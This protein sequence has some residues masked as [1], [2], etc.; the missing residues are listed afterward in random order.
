MELALWLT[1][2]MACAGVGANAVAGASEGHDQDPSEVEPL[3]DSAADHV[4]RGP[5][6]VD[7]V[8]NEKVRVDREIRS[9]LADAKACR[10]F[11]DSER[12]HVVEMGH[13]WQRVLCGADV[14]C[15]EPE[16]GFFYTIEQVDAVHDFERAVRSD[17]AKLA[18]D[19]CSVSKLPDAPEGLGDAS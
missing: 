8:R 9:L 18:E 10:A 3:D 19:G 12:A 6:R 1:L 14:Q 17:R 16:A 13:A 7:D 11:T 2:A 4:R 5:Y 15:A